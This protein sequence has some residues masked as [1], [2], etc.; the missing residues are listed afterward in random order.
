MIER[1]ITLAVEGEA[2]R[3]GRLI[4]L[5]ATTWVDGIPIMASREN[6]SIAGYVTDIAREGN[7][8]VGT[9]H[10]DEYP[11][12][13]HGVG[14]DMDDA[15]VGFTTLAEGSQ[16]LMVITQCRIRAITLVCNVA[17]DECLFPWVIAQ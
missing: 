10:F 7:L 17:W 14:A 15:E 13:T 2:T 1:R 3:D 5:G 11:S 8:I 12:G 9:A 16:P 4:K 6:D